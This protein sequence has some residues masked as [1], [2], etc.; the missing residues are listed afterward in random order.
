MAKFLLAASR[1]S[2]KS[3]LMFHQ[4][5][6]IEDFKKEYNVQGGLNLRVNEKSSHPAKLFMA[7]ATSDGIQ[8]TGAV[9]NAILNLEDAAKG[10]VVSVVSKDEAPEEYFALIHK[11]ADADKLNANLIGTL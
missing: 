9:S 1:P 8:H 4:T 10:T 3:G 11:E 2:N 5:L 7:F 6:S